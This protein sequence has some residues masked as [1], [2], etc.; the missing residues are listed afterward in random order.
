MGT[1]PLG[2]FFDDVYKYTDY[3]YSY[4][5]Y[6]QA[7]VT[8]MQILPPST[9]TKFAGNEN[10]I[11][12]VFT[13]IGDDYLSSLL[14]VN[15]KVADLFDT[16]EDNKM[17]DNSFFYIINKQLKRAYTKS[18]IS[19]YEFDNEFY[20]TSIYNLDADFEMSLEGNKYMVVSHSPF[21]SVL[22]YAY[23]AFVP[24]SDIKSVTF[25]YFWIVGEMCIRDRF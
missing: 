4:W 18:S 8:D 7:P 20:D 9:V 21:D 10:V 19:E 14:I 13:H 24:D 23:V 1:Y 12:M 3:S 17:T 22:G 2:E 6:Y 11:P 16:L 15:I 25:S 5:K